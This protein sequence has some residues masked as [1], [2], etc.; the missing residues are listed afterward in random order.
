M[1]EALKA[2]PFCGRAPESGDIRGG[3]WWVVECHCS[4]TAS[5]CTRREAEAIAA[6]NRRAPSQERAAIV[7]WLLSD[8]LGVSENPAVLADRIE[9]GEDL[10]ATSAVKEPG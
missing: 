6:W 1:S 7:A 3:D 9:R 2:C 8:A 4:V 10:P 5:V